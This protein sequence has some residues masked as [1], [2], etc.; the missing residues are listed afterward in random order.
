MTCAGEA[1]A[2]RMAGSLLNA[3]GLPDL[4]THDLADYESL[5]LKLATDPVKLAEVRARLAGRSASGPLFDSDRFRRHLEA[6]YTTM[7]ERAQRAEAP[8]S[9]VVQAL[10]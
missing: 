8:A 10:N 6:A 5:A 1:F 7:W 2:S 4:V 9:F 3:A